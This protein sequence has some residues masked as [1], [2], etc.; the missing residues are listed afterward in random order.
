VPDLY[1]PRTQWASYIVNAIK[2]GPPGVR[3]RGGAGRQGCNQG[4]R[5][6]TRGPGFNQGAR[7]QPGGQGSTRGPGA[8]RHGGLRQAPCS[9]WGAPTPNCE[10]PPTPPPPPGHPAGQGAFCSRRELHHK[11]RRGHHR[12]RVHGAHHAGPPLERRPAPG[13]GREAGP[14]GG[15]SGG[16]GR[17]GSE[18]GRGPHRAGP[19]PEGRPAPAARGA[20]LS[21]RRGSR[22]PPRRRRRPLAAALSLF[23]RAAPTCHRPTAPARPRPRPRPRPARP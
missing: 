18:A 10:Y 15:R 7:V 21:E 14:R 23:A 9:G 2:V 16:W 12:R 5:V 4:A 1:D 6:A 20:A 17:E 19:P 11:G 3:A 8:A 22:P 13:G